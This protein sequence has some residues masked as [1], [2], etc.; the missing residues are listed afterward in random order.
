MLIS[1]SYRRYNQQLHESTAAYGT[2]SSK[3]VET[4]RVLCAR[5]NA[6]SV[7]DYGC[8]KGLLKAN[9]G[10]IVHEYD[11]A[12]PDKSDPP[13]PADVVVCTDVLEHIEPECL[14]DVLDD[15]KRVT[16]C[17]GLLVVATTPAKK[18]LPDGRN[19]HLIVR[20]PR[21]WLPQILNRFDLARFE[22]IKN[23]FAAVV[24]PLSASAV[25]R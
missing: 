15:L 17:V 19:A 1:E 24:V 12:I 16:R 22:T 10:D 23:Q 20:P 21:W 6:A 7:L 9:L 14:D 3:W 2:S 18:T 8:G 11:P 13:Q 25:G 4:V 5:A